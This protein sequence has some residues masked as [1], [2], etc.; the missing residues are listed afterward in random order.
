M[1]LTSKEEQFAQS[2]ALKQMD[3]VTAYTT[4]YNVTK[5]SPGMIEKKANALSVKLEVQQRISVLRDR[6]MSASQ[7]K[8]QYD[9]A[10]AIAEAD[11]LIEDGKALGQIGAAVSAAQLKAKLAGHLV[12]RKEVTNK[13]GLEGA[14]VQTLEAMKKK[15]QRELD[16]AREAAELTGVEKP[17]T[18]AIRRIA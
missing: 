6:A 18:P 15:I 1:A 11:T 13:T 3:V 17:S 8:E 2:V 5:M 12:D 10:A 4:V 9:L 7:K 16:A 14:D